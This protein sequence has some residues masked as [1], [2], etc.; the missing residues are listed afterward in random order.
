MVGGFSHTC[1]LWSFR[2]LVYS[3]SA[4]ERK[5]TFHSPMACSSVIQIPSI[6]YAICRVTLMGPRKGDKEAASGARVAELLPKKPL[7]APRPESASARVWLA[8]DFYVSMPHRLIQSVLLAATGRT[9][10]R[11]I[12]IYTYYIAPRRLR[13]F[14][15][16]FR[17]RPTMTRSVVHAVL[18][19]PL[20]N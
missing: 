6:L 9:C 16:R 10:R 14:P 7:L 4:L 13:A 15:P 5:I 3:F 8:R 19:S 12:W 17:E 2:L 11:P 20:L 1:H 18:C